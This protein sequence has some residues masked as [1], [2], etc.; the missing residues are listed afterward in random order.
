MIS[1]FA[2]KNRI[3]RKSANRIR[4]GGGYGATLPQL[5]PFRASVSKF[6]KSKNQSIKAIAELL[7]DNVDGAIPGKEMELRIFGG[8]ISNFDFKLL[9]E[10]NQNFRLYTEE[11]RGGV[12]VNPGGF[13]GTSQ[14][15]PRLKLSDVKKFNPAAIGLSV[16]ASMANSIFGSNLTVLT[17][18][19]FD[20]TPTTAFASEVE[21]FAN[22]IPT[23]EFSR[24]VPFLDLIFHT[25]VPALNDRGKP[26]SISLS[27][28]AVGSEGAGRFE[29]GT[30]LMADPD[31][32]FGNS[33]ESKFGMEMFTTP[34]TFVPLNR[35]DRSI[36]I[37]HPFRPFMSIK[38]LDISV[39]PAMG[40]M[41]EKKKASLKIELHDRS[42]LHEISEIIRPQNFG[43][44]EILIEYGWSHPDT[45]GRNEYANFLNAMRS[46]EKFAVFNAAFS[47]NQNGGVDIDLTLFAK[48]NLAIENAS[49]IDNP[50][51][52]KT[53][54]V[55]GELEE[56]INKILSSNPKN[57]KKRKSISATQ[58]VDDFIKSDG[59]VNTEGLTMFL[60]TNNAPGPLA[61]LSS[62]NAATLIAQIEQLKKQSDAFNVKKTEIVQAI[63]SQLFTG[64]T[65]DPFYPESPSELGGLFAKARP[66]PG[67]PPIEY[68]SVGKLFSALV[69]RPLT[70][71]GKFAEVQLYFYGFSSESGFHD[72]PTAKAHLSDYSIDQFL[73]S[74]EGLVAALNKLFESNGSTDIPVQT[75]MNMIVKNYLKYPFSPLMDAVT[76]GQIYRKIMGN[77]SAKERTAEATAALLAGDIPAGS[78]MQAYKAL[79][80]KFRPPNVQVMFDSL[81]QSS[82]IPGSDSNTARSILRVHIFDANGGRMTPF[83]TALK[84]GNA[85]METLKQTA[86][87]VKDA[88][89][90]ESSK[91]DRAGAVNKILLD[92]AAADM[93]GVKPVGPGEWRLDLPFSK[94]KKIISNGFPTLTYGSDGSVLT[95]AKFSTIQNK[96]FANIQL[97]RF[98]KD[99]N[100]TAAGTE[101][102][103]LPLKILPTQADIAMIGCPV[104]RYGQTFFIDFGTGTSADDLYSAKT[105]QH[106]IT[107]GSFTSTLSLMPRDADGAYESLFSIL[108]KASKE[109]QFEAGSKVKNALLS[110]GEAIVDLSQ[111]GN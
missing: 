49:I 71:T 29:A 38:S 88:I 16:A 61:N 22:A 5:N 60:E 74:K 83:A 52:K 110:A 24:C 58:I 111:T 98:G 48:A 82:I 65:D 84:A 23:V 68:I 26:L 28:A 46:K 2:K 13:I 75:F 101:P 36:P 53:S 34:Q 4:E 93:F 97:A 6:D 44:N 7:L 95:S 3:L 31:S 96:K 47:L 109:L 62:P 99:P 27:K 76:P 18:K 91:R 9:S 66:V 102:N 41:Q 12:G 37:L 72:A 77:M 103:G 43:T 57:Q 20:F 11:A 64:P 45:S 30:R 108:N 8:Q 40:G 100:K 25:A 10:F 32:I 90:L 86:K 14:F 50:A 17:C 67:K 33:K 35:S 80:K 73:I 106:K 85:D 51:L 89:G 55:I 15:A 1:R 78:P 87:S 81:P 54:K 79:A 56:K 69:G 39:V 107:P 19:H 92:C 105:V 70:S 104:L 94:L 59:S 21:V 42:R 63:I